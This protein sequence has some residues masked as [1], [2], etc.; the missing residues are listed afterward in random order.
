MTIA[1]IMVDNY[2]KASVVCTECS[3]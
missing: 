2:L 3:R 1:V